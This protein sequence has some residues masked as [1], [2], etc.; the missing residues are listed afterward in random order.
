MFITK[1]HSLILIHLPN[2]YYLNR[3]Y[4]DLKYFFENNFLL[5]LLIITNPII[6]ISFNF[7]L[8]IL[9]SIFKEDFLILVV[10]FH[11]LEILFIIYLIH[12]LNIHYLLIF[13][14]NN[15]NYKAKN[16]IFMLILICYFLN[17]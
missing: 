14:T 7:Y 9:V 17:C 1:F 11:N 3:I 12:L 15:Q 6:F 8:I 4:L 13:F 2:S 5:H 10:Y 16:S